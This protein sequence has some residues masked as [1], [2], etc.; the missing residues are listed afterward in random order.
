MKKLFIIAAAACVTL[1]SCVKNEPVQTPQTFDEISFDSPI[2]A[3]SVKAGVAEVPTTYND[4]PFMVRA[5]F[6]ATEGFAAGN[7]YIKAPDVENGVSISK[8]NSVWKGATSYYWPKSGYLHFSA[9]SPASAA[10]ATIT[11]TGVKFTSYN[12]S[13]T[14]SEQVDLLFSDRNYDVV[15]TVVDDEVQPVSIVFNHALSA[16]DF[17][18]AASTA[19]TF[20]LK[21]ITIQDLYST[22]SFD[23]ALS[24][25]SQIGGN[26]KWTMVGDADTDYS[27]DVPSA[28]VTLDGNVKYAHSGGE[29]GTNASLILLPQVVAGKTVVVTYTMDGFPQQSEFTLA[30]ESEWVRGYRYT[31]AISFGV[32]EIT[33]TPSAKKWAT[34]TGSME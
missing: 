25:G 18:V 13:T 32:D 9:Y 24:A 30:D 29:K 8:S 34:G 22:G 11:E 27:V 10:N 14:V 28:G 6:T 17:T 16:I 5:W 21:S 7:D 33:F 3:P 20:V 1:A 31:Y 23:Q 2:L 4:S 26:V 19:A 15:K 12:V